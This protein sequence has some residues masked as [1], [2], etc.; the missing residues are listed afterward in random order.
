MLKKAILLWVFLLYLTV[1]FGQR[2]VQFLNNNLQSAISMAQARNKLI[3]VDTYAP[4]CIPCKKMEKV[5]RDPELARYFNKTFVNLRVDMEGATGKEI[6]KKY[7]V[8]FLPTL[9]IL[10]SDGNVKYMV[11]ELMTADALLAVAQKIAEPEVYVYQPAENVTVF[12]PP[13]KQEIVTKSVVKKSA[14][15]V[16]TSVSPPSIS[17]QDVV[18]ESSKTVLNE[19]DIKTSSSVTPDQVI[20]EPIIEGTIG[21]E[22]ILYVL[23]ESDDVPPE[24]LFQESYFRL[25][26]MDGSH[27]ETAKLYIQSQE[28]WST[29]KNRKFIYDFLY[30]TD[31]EEFQYFINNRDAFENQ[32]GKEN[33]KQSVEILVSRRLITGFPRPTLAEAKKLYAYLDHSNSERMA[34]EYHLNNLF[35][36]KNHDEFIEV[37][38]AYLEEFDFENQQVFYRLANLIADGG[39]QNLVESGIEY[40]DKAIELNDANYLYYDTKAYL[41]YLNDDKK[42]ARISALRSKEIAS[43]LGQDTQKIEVLLEMIGELE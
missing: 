17:T 34:Y 22:K 11:D 37:A 15:G 32:F 24:I 20:N 19:A 29:L 33:V 3:F 1:G 14:P 42:K 23:N 35:L 43:K 40:I 36:A 12:D 10:D 7:N 4:W 21:E 8:I 6:H 16:T 2:S 31:T 13:A 25:Q 41:H 18:V 5:F 39:D 30:S 9:M 28:D 27:K 26:L 38:E